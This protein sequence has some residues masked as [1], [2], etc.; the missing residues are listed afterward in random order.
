M[1]LGE[2][3][4]R[5]WLLRKATLL[6]PFHY[7][8]LLHKPNIEAEP[9]VFKLQEKQRQLDQKWEEFLILLDNSVCC[10]GPVQL[11]MRP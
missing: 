8:M 3:A 11:R 9:E 5:E 10:K 1:S 6:A 7:K 2:K 4:G